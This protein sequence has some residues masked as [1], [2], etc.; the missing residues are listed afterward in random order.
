MFFHDIRYAFRSISRQPT[1]AAMAILTLVLGIGANTAIFSVVKA[2]LLNRLPYE[3][4]SDLVVLWEQNPN[5]SPD[6][7]APPTFKDWQSQSRAVESMAGD[8]PLRYSV[9][10]SP[11]KEDPLHGPSIPPTPNLLGVL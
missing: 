11:V 7:V 5:G 4:P 1:F 9:A 2:V 10:G 6:L 8:R 3:K